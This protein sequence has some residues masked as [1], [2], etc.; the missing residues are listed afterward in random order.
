LNLRN[1]QSIAKVTEPLYSGPPIQPIGPA[2]EAPV[3]IHAT[4]PEKSVELAIELIEKLINIE[5]LSN[6]DIAVLLPNRSLCGRTERSL[7][8]F[9]IRSVAAGQ[10]RSGAIVV[11]TIRRFKGLE[12]LVVV[13]VVDRI[14]AEHQELCYV[15]VSRARSRLFVVGDKSPL[16]RAI[17]ELM[18]CFY[19]TLSPAE[20]TAALEKHFQYQVDYQFGKGSHAKLTGTQL[21]MLIIP[22]RDPVSREVFASIVADLGYRGRR[23]ELFKKLHII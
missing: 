8:Q 17:T 21:P 11:D 7:G 23:R 10:Q 13:L 15:A 14:T 20:L 2:G 16:S 12:S 9:H 6:E 18:D 19:L 5:G 4:S 3:A 22:R 1:T